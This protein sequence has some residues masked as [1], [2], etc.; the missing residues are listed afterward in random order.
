MGQPQHHIVQQQQPH[1]RPISSYYEYET[2]HK[3]PARKSSAPPCTPPKLNGS[4]GGGSGRH[5]GPFVTQVT[6]R[7]Q[8]HLI[9]SG[10]QQPASKV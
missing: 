5:R 7:D 8:H 6:I 9:H 1:Q 3:F 10:Q 4:I 2:I